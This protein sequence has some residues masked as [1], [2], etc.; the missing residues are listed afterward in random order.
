MYYKVWSDA[1][2][3]RNSIFGGSSAPDMTQLEVQYGEAEEFAAQMHASNPMHCNFLTHLLIA[4]LAVRAA[5][6]HATTS[7]PFLE[8]FL[9]GEV[10]TL[11]DAQQKVELGRI[12]QCFVG[13]HKPSP[14]P[15]EAKPF[16]VGGERFTVTVS[17]IQHIPAMIRQIMKNC[18]DMEAEMLLGKLIVLVK[19]TSTAC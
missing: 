2:A 5:T 1:E 18:E 6:D 11:T 12:F 17:Q 19:L 14:A 16:A 8:L 3:R 15:G 9:T 13:L 10:G 7:L 4:G